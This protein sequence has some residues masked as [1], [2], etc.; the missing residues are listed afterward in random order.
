[1]MKRISRLI[2]TFAIP[3]MHTRSGGC[4][5]PSMRKLLQIRKGTMAFALGILS[6]TFCLSTRADSDGPRAQE[7]GPEDGKICC[8]GTEPF[9]FH[10]EEVLATTGRAGVFRSESR[11]AHW[12]RSMSGLVAPNGVSPFVDFVCQSPSQPNIITPSWG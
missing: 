3:I 10:G 12:Q 9:H 1:M 5:G 6:L 11:G 2:S 4:K 8:S 7:A